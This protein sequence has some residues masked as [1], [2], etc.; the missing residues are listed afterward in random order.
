MDGKLNGITQT[1]GTLSGVGTV[2][3]VT[4]TTPTTAVGGTVAPGDNAGDAQPQG[5]LTI[6][7]G[8]GL[9][10]NFGSGTT[11]NFDLTRA[12]TGAGVAGGYD[13]L[14]VSSGTL[15]LGGANVTGVVGPD[16]NVGD[17]FTII[18]LTGGAFLG[19]TKF[20]TADVVFINGSKFAVTYN[21]GTNGSVVLERQ[22]TSV[23]TTVTSLPSPVKYGDTGS[24]VI[25]ATLTAEQ[26]AGPVPDG[27]RSR[28]TS[29]TAPA[30]CC[31][32]GHRDDERQGDVRP[33]AGIGVVLSP[34][35]YT[36]EAIP[37]PMN[38]SPRPRPPRPRRS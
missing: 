27:S 33:A 30:T 16:V 8:A 35:T 13:Q 19:A 31:S 21:T 2:G 9:A 3:R 7:P 4:G 1:G 23:S 25:T 20:A 34:G 12:S 15:N 18:Q 5:K 29:R 10:E 17:R 14:V 22:L 28:S 11:L 24:F 26:G 38:G 32:E 6:N 37:A 36:V